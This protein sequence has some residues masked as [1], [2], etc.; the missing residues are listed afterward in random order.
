LPGGLANCDEFV[1]AQ[2]RQVAYL[3][4]HM[5]RHYNIAEPRL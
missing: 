4:E 1:A 2:I 3:T 5:P